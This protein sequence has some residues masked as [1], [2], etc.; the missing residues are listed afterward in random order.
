MHSSS[1]VEVLDGLSAGEL[2]LVDGQYALP[3]G[4]PIE[5]VQSANE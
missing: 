5:A 2:V 4:T 1:R 3:D